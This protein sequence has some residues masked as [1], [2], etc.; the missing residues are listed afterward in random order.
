[1]RAAP[2]S[3]D[4]DRALGSR[5]AQRDGFT[6]LPRV[7]YEATDGHTGEDVMLFAGGPGAERFAGHLDNTDIP[8]RIAEILGWEPPNP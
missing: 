2:T 8:K 3:Y 7:I 4:A 6:W 5:V 1:M